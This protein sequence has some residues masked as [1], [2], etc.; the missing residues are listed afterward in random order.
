MRLPGEVEPGVA[1]KLLCKGF[2][3]KL[4]RMYI[5]VLTLLQRVFLPSLLIFRFHFE[6]V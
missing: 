4:R 2:V 6:A 5:R 3:E 1:F